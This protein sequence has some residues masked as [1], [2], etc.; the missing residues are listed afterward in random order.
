MTKVIKFFRVLT[1]EVSLFLL[2]AFQCLLLQFDVSDPKWLVIILHH[3]IKEQDHLHYITKWQERQTSH[4]PRPLPVEQNF[5]SNR[6]QKFEGI[7]R[8]KICTDLPFYQSNVS[9]LNCCKRIHPQFLYQMFSIQMLQLSASIN[10]LR[11]IQSK[12]TESHP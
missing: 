9:A 8:F 4:L 2:V 12:M 11:R 7:E 6:S 5:V 3:H 10:H 1:I